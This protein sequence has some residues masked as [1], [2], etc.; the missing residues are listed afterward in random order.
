MVFRGR[1]SGHADAIHVHVELISTRG[2]SA[3]LRQRFAVGASE[4]K[5]PS[6]DAAQ[7]CT[8]SGSDDSPGMGRGPLRGT[9]CC[10]KGSMGRI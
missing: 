1:F 4:R 9:V 8:S 6:P 5:L 2:S 10:I 3:R 7:F